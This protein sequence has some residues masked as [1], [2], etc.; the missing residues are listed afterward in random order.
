M[1]F[2]KEWFDQLGSML[3]LGSKRG[4]LVNPDKA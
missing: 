4:F 1:I 3:A 2:G